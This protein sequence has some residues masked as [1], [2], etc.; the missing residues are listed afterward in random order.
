MLCTYVLLVQRPYALSAS[1]KGCHAEALPIFEEAH[2]I[3]LAGHILA[4][5]ICNGVRLEHHALISM[6]A[7]KIAELRQLIRVG[8]EAESA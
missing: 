6:A 2:T 5:L 3:W 7:E 8:T 4:T 1:V